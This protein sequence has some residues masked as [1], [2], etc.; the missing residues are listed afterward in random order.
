MSGLGGLKQVKINKSFNSESRT[1]NFYLDKSK[2]HRENMNKIY[3]I[4]TI[5]EEKTDFDKRFPTFKSQV[6]KEKIK[7]QT[8]SIKSTEINRRL[9]QYPITKDEILNYLLRV[10]KSN[11]KLDPNSFKN[12]LCSQGFKDII[13]EVNEVRLKRSRCK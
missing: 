4:K 11:D 9:T 3:G 7:M 1:N 13:A 10:K 5:K 12:R 2:E 8:P 6:T